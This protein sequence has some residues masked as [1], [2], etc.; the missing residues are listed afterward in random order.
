MAV[1]KNLNNSNECGH[2][3]QMPAIS[4]SSGGEEFYGPYL[5]LGFQ[6][7]AHLGYTTPLEGEDPQLICALTTS[8]QQRVIFQYISEGTQF[9]LLEGQNNI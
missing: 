1:S 2:L 4:T 5:T 8:S 3:H 9:Q 7:A 6:I